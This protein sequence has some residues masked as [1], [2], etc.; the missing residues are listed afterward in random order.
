M[1]SSRHHV[2][3]KKCRSNGNKEVKVID[4]TDHSNWHNLVKNLSPDEAL[5]FIA[6][7]FLPT[8]Y[9]TKILEMIDDGHTR[10]RNKAVGNYPQNC[11]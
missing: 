2:Y 3:S 11:T 5:R 9:E 1:H 7:N 10:P 8:D 6:I 4:P